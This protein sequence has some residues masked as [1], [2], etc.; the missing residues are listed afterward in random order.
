[1]DDTRALKPALAERLSKLLSQG[2]VHD[3]VSELITQHVSLAGPATPGAALHRARWFRQL[4]ETRIESR[5][6]LD[7]LLQ[8]D[9]HNNRARRELGAWWLGETSDPDARH[10]A[11]DQLARAARGSDGD[12]AAA[13]LLALLTTDPGPLDRFA[14][15]ADG[16]QVGERSN[17]IN[18]DDRRSQ[19][20]QGHFGAP[21]TGLAQIDPARLRLVA[22]IIAERRAGMVLYR[23]PAAFRP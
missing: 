18:Q 11:T 16:A 23:L 9:P 8:A 7:A 19:T 10:L 22:T 21:S 15:L 1:M 6:I 5:R 3:G 20:T 13:V 2:K 12:A 14:R 4:P 17:P